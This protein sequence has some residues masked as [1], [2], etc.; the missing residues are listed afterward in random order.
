V[1]PTAARMVRVGGGGE[2]GPRGGLDWAAE[3]TQEEERGG[4]PRLGRE[5]GWAARRGGGERREKGFF[6]FSNLFA[7]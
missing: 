5:P 7:K 4:K 6:P 3:P 2:A 1:V